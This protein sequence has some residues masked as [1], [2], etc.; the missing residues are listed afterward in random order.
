VG[1]R[2]GHLGRVE[3]GSS[4]V[5][6]YALKETRIIKNLIKFIMPVCSSIQAIV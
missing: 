1:E 5:H 3:E 2:D 4:R 6:Q